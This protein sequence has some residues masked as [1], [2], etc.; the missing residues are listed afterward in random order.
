MLSLTARDNS[1]SPQTAVLCGK[2]DVQLSNGLY[3]VFGFFYVSGLKS[4]YVKISA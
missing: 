2:S 1:L 4:E 3:L